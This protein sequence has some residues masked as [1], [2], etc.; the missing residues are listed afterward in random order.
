[1]RLTWAQLGC[2]TLGQAETILR[3]GSPET[4]GGFLRLFAPLAGLAGSEA[5]R[6]FSLVGHKVRSHAAGEA[7]LPDWDPFFAALRR[8][9]TARLITERTTLHDLSE[10]LWEMH[11]AQGPPPASRLGTSEAGS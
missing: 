7:A 1:M 6:A 11:T 2:L 8:E 4:H 10:L 5:A 9:R 3:E